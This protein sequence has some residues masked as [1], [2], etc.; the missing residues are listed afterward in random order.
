[1]T[2]SIKDLK[3]LEQQVTPL[4]K[5]AGKYIV[6]HWHTTHTLSYKDKRDVASEVDIEVENMLRE[7]LSE[8]LPEAG[9]IVEEGETYKKNLNWV[10]DPIDGTKYYVAG[11]P[12]FFTQIALLE[13]NIPVIGHVYNPVGE[14]LFSAS[15]GNGAYLNGNKISIQ[16]RTKPEESIINVDFGGN[17]SELE[18][19]LKIL[20]QVA[21]KFYRVRMTGNYLYPYL[22][23][24][25]IDV[26]LTLNATTKVVDYMPGVAIIRE[27]GLIAE[28]VSIHQRKIL[29]CSNTILFEVIK[30]ILQ[31]TPYSAQ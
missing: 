8:I 12:V 6:D 1:M 20:S 27:S 30:D 26:S 22:V 18:W 19:K 29:V 31:N 5:S 17:D 24:G 10:I 2:L 16:L 14:Q 21:Q 4:I 7:K 25:G 3:Y 9:F 23:T 28:Y 11:I 13:D 15:K